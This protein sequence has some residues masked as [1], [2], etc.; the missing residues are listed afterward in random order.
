M[1]LKMTKMDVW[2]AEIDDNPADSREP[3]GRSPTTERT[4]TV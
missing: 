4:S 1:R 3:C 2:A